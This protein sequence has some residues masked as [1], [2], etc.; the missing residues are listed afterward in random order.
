MGSSGGLDIGSPLEAI[1]TGGM[2][3]VSRR[4]GRNQEALF[5]ISTGG[6]SAVARGARREFVDKPRELAERAARE[7]EE[8]AARLEQEQKDAEQKNKDLAARNQARAKQRALLGS[9][10]GRAG[11]I[12]TSPLGIPPATD[13]Q[14]PKTLLGV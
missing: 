7:Q 12:L 5:D 6:V 9:R 14:G 4:A 2:S 10:S 8:A 13:G 1:F 3:P 11:T